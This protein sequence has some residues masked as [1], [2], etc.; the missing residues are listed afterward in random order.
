MIVE[1]IN[2]KINCPLSSG[3]GRLFDAVA[4]ITG[5]CINGL[6]HA[7]APMRLESYANPDIHDCYHYEI[8]N[9]ISFLPAIRQICYDLKNG[10]AP[11]IISS[12]FHNTLADASMNMVRR[13]SG[14]TGINKVVLSGGTF[15]NKYLLELL[16]NMLLKDNFAVFTHC[17]VP[18]N[19]GG[20]ALGQ[21]AVAARR[22]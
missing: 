22:K 15:Q 12:R 19:D 18:C 17:K 6:Y 9:N 3:A 14:N 20:V 7:E 2:K 16:E 1:A 5:I 4:A 8:N 21:L 11:D 10:I 13:I